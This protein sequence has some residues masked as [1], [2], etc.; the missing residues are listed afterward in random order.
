MSRVQNQGTVTDIANDQG[1]TKAAVEHWPKRYDDF[2][3]P[4][5]KAAAGRLWDLDVVDRWCKKR[6]VGRHRT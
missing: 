3:L 5:R 2:P 4:V 1:V 6:G